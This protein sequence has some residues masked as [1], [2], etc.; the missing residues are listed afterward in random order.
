MNQSCDRTT[1]ISACQ[2][3]GNQLIINLD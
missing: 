3:T 1:P 2:Q